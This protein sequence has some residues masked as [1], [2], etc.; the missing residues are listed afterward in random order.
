MIVSVVIM[1]ICITIGG[2]M[3]RSCMGKR[4][5][6][7]EIKKSISDVKQIINQKESLKYKNKIK[8]EIV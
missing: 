6:S 3:I 2:F 7:E 1:L 5:S 4:D 8:R